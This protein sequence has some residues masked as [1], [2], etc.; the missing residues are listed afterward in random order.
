MGKNKGP[1]NR[2]DWIAVPYRPGKV[3]LLI[4]TS[5]LAGVGL[6]YAYNHF[7]DKLS[8]ITQPLTQERQTGTKEKKFA[9]V[10]EVVGDV[11]V[12]KVNRVNW[13]AARQVEYLEEGDLLQTESGSSA[14][15]VFFDGSSYFVNPDSL[16]VV[17][18]SYENPS[19]NVRKVSLEITSG[20][21]DLST[22]QK[23][24]EGSSFEIQTANA[25]ASFESFSEGKAK[26]DKKIKESEFSIYRGGAEVSSVGKEPS[27]VRLQALEKV[28]LDSN[29]KFQPKSKL[30]EPPKLLEPKNPGLFV[31]NEP[32]SLVVKLKWAK[33]LGARF[34]RLRV[35]PSSTFNPLIINQLVRDQNS[36]ALRI[37]DYGAY[38][39]RINSLNAEGV[40]SPPSDIFSF[41]ILQRRTGTPR[42]EISIRIEKIIP[43]GNSFEVIGMTDPG[44][45]V[46]INEEL[47]DVKGDGSFKHFT[48]PFRE[49]GEHNLVVVARDLA[50][51]SK[52]ITE[53]VEV[54]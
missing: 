47:A 25:S 24:A 42:H 11:K 23:T 6:I 29:S 19:S 54:K 41:G 15:I 40:E 36:F 35:S 3:G 38:Y 22:S 44:V 50:G 30:P 31:T 43:F 51:P 52:T 9:R 46:V 17:Q 10:V 53:T 37:P 7:K 2:V 45:S 4:L 39:W 27:K 12:K 20:T 1:S 26:Y 18:K 28:S 16:V 8:S 34:Y 5:V 21:V 33:V 48:R 32:K 13:V 49:K 14:R